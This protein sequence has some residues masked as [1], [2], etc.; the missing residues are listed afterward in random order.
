MVSHFFTRR[1]HLHPD[2][3]TKCIQ[4][5]NSSIDRNTVVLIALIVRYLRLVYI[6]PTGEF[7]LTNPFS[8][9]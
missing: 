9:A 7:T 3:N 1:F 6:K 8:D 4:D 2:L 5:P